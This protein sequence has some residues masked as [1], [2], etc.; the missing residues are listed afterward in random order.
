MNDLT[1]IT[2]ILKYTALFFACFGYLFADISY[3]RGWNLLGGPVDLSNATNEEFWTYR[4][5]IW[6]SRPQKIQRHQGFWFKSDGSGKLK[7]YTHDFQEKLPSVY[8]LYS[9][10]IQYLKLQQE[11]NFAEKQVSNS[12]MV[13]KKDLSFEE[14]LIIDINATKT[15]KNSYKGKFFP[16]VDITNRIVE[17]D[18]KTNSYAISTIDLSSRNLIIIR[19]ESSPTL[20]NI[21]KKYVYVRQ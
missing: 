20:G 18:Q 6:V 10:D 19:F 2:K 15:L 9:F 13:I 7:S 5:G 21:H 12:Y 4:N 17:Y 1:F 16:M 14:H 11:R 8:Y 3:Q